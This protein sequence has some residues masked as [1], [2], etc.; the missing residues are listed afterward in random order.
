MAPGGVGRADRA[1]SAGDGRRMAG[2]GRVGK[3][4][5]VEPRMVRPGG[6]GG[7]DA[8]YD[9]FKRLDKVQYSPPVRPD[10]SSMRVRLILWLVDIQH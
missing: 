2:S 4:G 1:G 9:C 3:G 6:S 8:L 10:V 7:N 5:L